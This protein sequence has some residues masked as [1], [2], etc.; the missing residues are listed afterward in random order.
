MPTYAHSV[1]DIASIGRLLGD[2]SR[3]A[4]ILALMD[5]RAWTVGEIARYLGIAKSTATAHAHL[6]VDG[7]L[8]AE[9]HQ[10]RHRYLRPADPDVAEAVEALG[11][12]SGTMLSPRRTLSAGTRDAALRAGRTCHRHLAG[13]LGVDLLEA[14]HEHGSSPEPGNSGPTEP[15]G[16]PGSTSRP[17][18]PD[19]RSCDR[20]WTGPNGA[21]ISQA[22]T[23]THCAITCCAS[24]GLCAAGLPVLYG[25]PTK[26]ESNP[27]S[28]A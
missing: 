19:A 10:G 24:P 5:G 23:A 2:E 18:H 17:N 27:R 16:S 25:S 8:L 26:G 14:L 9:A 7:G 3:A 21:I 12:L 15:S 22:S 4:M 1:P 13:R 11:A 20:V 28:S 6:L